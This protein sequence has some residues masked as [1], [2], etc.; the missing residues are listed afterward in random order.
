MTLKLFSALCYSLPLTLNLVC[1]LDTPNH[2]GGGSF[3]GMKEEDRHMM[4][5]RA[6][7]KGQAGY[8][9]V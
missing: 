9:M 2:L 1:N 6:I 7:A 3:G 4:G 8:I 5:K